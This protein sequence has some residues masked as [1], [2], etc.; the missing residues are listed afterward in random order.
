M[1]TRDVIKAANDAELLS[2]IINV[3]P[4]LRENI[5]LPRQGE[6]IKEIG[7]LIIDNQRYRNAFINTINLIGLTVIK[8][9][10]WRDPWDFTERGFLRYGQQIREIIV[11]LVNV[12]DYNEEFGNKTKFLETEVPNVFNYIHELNFQKFYA[13]TTSDN[14]LRMAFE[15]EGGLFDFVDE[16][17]SMMYE[18]YVYDRYQIN[19][20]M[21]ARRILDGTV[22]PAY[23]A[24]YANMTPRQRVSAMKSVSN[25]FT[26]RSPNY[27][28]AG[29]R[30]ATSFDDQILIVNTDFEADFSTDVM[31]TSYFRNEADMR[32]RMVLADGFGNFDTPRLLEVLGSQFVEFTEDELTALEAI[33]A[34]LISREWFMN[35]TYALD[36]ESGEKYTEFF[37]PTTLQNNHFMH[38]WKLFSSS[39]FENAAVF[40]SVEPTVTGVTVS[41]AT[42]TVTAGQNLTLSATVATTGFANKAVIWSV[43]DTSAAAGV[44]IT[45]AGVLTVPASIASDTEITVTATSVYD[46]SVTGTATITV[47]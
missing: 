37:N 7:K 46:D 28:P 2:Y 10:G 20:Y 47:A 44:T 14:Q 16:C 41:P 5:D 24:G 22:T 33:P 12:Y 45:A 21:L 19:K 31:A 39:P 36:G 17:I 25:K 4:E 32:A 26:F 9:N 11:D 43:D 35:Y 27:N 13:V 3:T 6:S 23:I 40:E 38:V 1:A 15:S 42:A 30:R 18:S 8:R 29:V 34:V